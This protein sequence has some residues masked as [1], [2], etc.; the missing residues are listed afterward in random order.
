MLTG[1]ESERERGDGKGEREGGRENKML[2]RSLYK[3]RAF[4]P[5]MHVIKPAYYLLLAADKQCGG[6]VLMNGMQVT[7]CLFTH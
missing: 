4:V 3:L 1:R 6:R 2:A 5:S 7:E